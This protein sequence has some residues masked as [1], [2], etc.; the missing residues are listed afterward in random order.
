[1]RAFWGGVILRKHYP[2]LSLLPLLCA[3]YMI[4]YLD[5][6]NIATAAPLIQNEL[7]V[8]NAAL[9]VI[10]SAFAYSYALCQLIGGFVGERFGARNTLVASVLVV[11]IATAA[12]GFAPGL[13]ALVAVRI[14]LGFGEGA[15][16]PTAT[17]LMAKQ[18]PQAQWGFAQGITHSFAR[19]GNFATPP[20]VAGLIALS[21]WRTSFYV[22]ACIGLIWVAAWLVWFRAPPGQ[23]VGPTPEHTAASWFDVAKQTAPATAVNFCYGWTLW[24]FLTWIPSF[25]VQNYHVSL[26][27]SAL[28][29]A[30]VFLGGFAG[31][32]FGG[33]L[34]DRILWRTRDAGSARRSVIIAGFLGGCVFLLP[35]MFVSDV[36][37]AAILLSLAFFFAELIV[38]P[39]WAITMEMVP[40]HPGA[41]SGVMNFGSAFAG[42]VSPLFFGVMVDV[43]GS[44]MI[45]F[46]LSVVL[47]VLGAWL[48]TA[49]RPASVDRARQSSLGYRGNFSLPRFRNFWRARQE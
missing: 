17:Q 23:S 28:Y 40:Q 26:A 44:W 34:S 8:S 3:L 39:I 48:A 19:L 31:D 7:H 27:G 2:V 18:L 14:A 10:L 9:G 36:R 46:A 42:I 38:A 35:V 11:C 1:M 37:L 45:P 6:V 47:L 16:L 24:L 29:S 49:L 13:L 15:A 30:G 32:A 5:R 25:F 33:A 43:T 22:F 12:T 4:L 21:S 41:A 20:L